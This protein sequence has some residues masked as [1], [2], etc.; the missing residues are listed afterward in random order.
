MCAGSNE[1]TSRGVLKNLSGSNVGMV[2]LPNMDDWTKTRFSDKV[3]RFSLGNKELQVAGSHPTR[4]LR[5]QLQS[6]AEVGII[7]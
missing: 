3:G 6:R 2:C 4:D 1:K 5:K 7:L